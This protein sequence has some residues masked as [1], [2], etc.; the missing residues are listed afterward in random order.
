MSTYQFNTL[1]QA[2]V[3]CIHFYVFD[4][5]LLELSTSSMNMAERP[6]YTESGRSCVNYYRQL[7]TQSGHSTV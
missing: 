5:P 2:N 1:F 4:C 3:M 7:T 6:L